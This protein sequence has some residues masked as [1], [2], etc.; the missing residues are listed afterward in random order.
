MNFLVASFLQG[1][2]GPEDLRAVTTV[3]R[4][5]QRQSMI[6]PSPQ[7]LTIEVSRGRFFAFFAFFVF[8]VPDEAISRHAGHEQRVQQTG[9]HRIDV[10]DPMRGGE[11]GNFGIATMPRVKSD[12]KYTVGFQ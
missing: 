4:P 5:I 8:F 10:G 2:G 6:G 7:R 3:P 9:S 1:A 11:S 12:S